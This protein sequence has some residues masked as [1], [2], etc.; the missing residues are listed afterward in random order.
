VGGVIVARQDLFSDQGVLRVNFNYQTTV[1]HDG[2]TLYCFVTERGSES[3]TLHAQPGDRLIVNLT[4]N[5]PADASTAMAA[6]PGMAISAA[7]SSAP[8][9]EYS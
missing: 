4:N 5:V 8:R 1:D 7:P 3:R 6:M 9:R 2:N